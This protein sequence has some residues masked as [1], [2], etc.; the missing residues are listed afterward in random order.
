MPELLGVA[1]MD[2]SVIVTQEVL[3]SR[4]DASS[5]YE[6]VRADQTACDVITPTPAQLQALRARIQPQYGNAVCT[7]DDMTFPGAS[8][9]PQPLSCDARANA[10]AAGGASAATPETPS[11]DAS[12]LGAGALFGFIMAALVSMCFF[13]AGAAYCAKSQ[14]ARRPSP[15]HTSSCSSSSSAASRAFPHQ[16]QPPPVVQAHPVPGYDYPQQPQPVGYSQGVAMGI[17]VA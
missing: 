14:A 3:D 16:Q 10:S 7:A 4:S 17:P 2:V 11:E 5:F 1:C 15:V 12:S 9:L 8:E 13:I 6:R